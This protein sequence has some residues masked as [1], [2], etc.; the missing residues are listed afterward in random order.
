MENLNSAKLIVK[1][2]L[3]KDHYIEEPEIKV[4]SIQARKPGPN[5]KTPRL[6]EIQECAVGFFRFCRLNYAAMLNISPVIS[7]ILFLGL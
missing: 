1:E 4:S 5:I 3:E 6:S 2:Q 7:H